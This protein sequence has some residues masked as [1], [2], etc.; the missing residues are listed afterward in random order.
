VPARTHE[1][2]ADEPCK[3]WKTSSVEA[4]GGISKLRRFVGVQP[5]AEILREAKDLW[6]IQRP[7]QDFALY[8]RLLLTTTRRFALPLLG[9]QKHEL[10]MFRSACYISLVPRVHPGL[11]CTVS[12]CA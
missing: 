3:K 1:N 4:G 11:L 2:S 7:L 5:A 12:F 8:N 10:T 9:M 6:D